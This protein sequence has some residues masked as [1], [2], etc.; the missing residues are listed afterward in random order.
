MIRPLPRCPGKLKG[1]VAF[2]LIALTAVAAHAQQARETP[3]QR[4]AQPVSATVDSGAESLGD[5]LRESEAAAPETLNAADPV[6]IVLGSGPGPRGRW[7]ATP[8]LDMR[9]TYDDNIFIRHRDRVDDFVF[10]LSPGVAL[11]YW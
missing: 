5:L 1:S 3:A 11:G 10:A 2:G 6:A 8:H 4:D 9:A 7:R